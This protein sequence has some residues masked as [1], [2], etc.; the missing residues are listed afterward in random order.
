MIEPPAS[1]L[2]MTVDNEKMNVFSM[3]SRPVPNPVHDTG[4]DQMALNALHVAQEAEKKA[5]DSNWKQQKKYWQDVEEKVAQ[6]N[7]RLEQME[8][9]TT[10]EIEDDLKD[11]DIFFEN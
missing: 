9:T 5:A 3:L 6:L 8:S 7:R 4:A 1:Y 10:S 2:Q 11:I